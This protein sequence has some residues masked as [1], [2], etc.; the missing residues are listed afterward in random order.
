MSS[1]T[2]D[3]CNKNFSRK[4]N[5][6]KHLQICK[7]KKEQDYIKSNN[8]LELLKTENANL[9]SQVK[10]LTDDLELLK[11]IL[12]N[13]SKQPTKQTNNT[14]NNNITINT[15]QSLRDLISNLDP[16]NFEEMKSVFENDLS[17]KYIDKGIEGIARFICE[18]PCR[19]KFFTTDY[20]RKVITYKT[21]DDQIISDPKATILLNTAIKQNADTIIDKAEGRY[22]YW[23]S[24]IDESR[25]EDIEPDESD[26]EHKLHTKKLK[27]IAQ[28]VKDNISVDST[29]ATNVIILKGIVNKSVVNEIE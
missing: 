26:L 10:I 14:Q 11:N 3:F 5:Y 12:E 20:S 22:Q 1:T 13:Q 7:I 27:T 9:K 23:K 18:V 19:D 6:N 2:C 4:S 8:E 28:K 24:Q 29:E 15:S 17:N 21:S 16:I 25:E